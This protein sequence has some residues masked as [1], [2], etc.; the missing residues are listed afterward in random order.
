MSEL[1]ITKGEWSV[2]ETD[3]GLVWVDNDC[4]DNICDMYHKKNSNDFYKKPNAKENADLIAEA[5]NVANETGLTPRQLLEQRDELLR[6]VK[7]MKVCWENDAKPTHPAT[8]YSHAVAA[9]AKAEAK[10]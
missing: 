10:P 3:A 7:G 8:W 4:G 9:I 1:K 2:F 6:I 5:G